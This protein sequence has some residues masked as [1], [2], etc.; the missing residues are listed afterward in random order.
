M[1]LKEKTHFS[2]FFLLISKLR[3]KLIQKKFNHLIKGLHLRKIKRPVVFYLTDLFPKQPPARDEFTHGGQ[4]KLVYLAEAFPHAY[5]FANILYTV[6]SI[7]H[8]LTHKIVSTA[9]KKKMKII[10]NQNGVAYSAWHGPGWEKPNLIHQSIL[11]QADY[12]IYQS[13][14]CQVSAE[15]FLS[16]PDVPCEIIYNPVDVD[17]FTPIHLSKKPKELTLLLG[18]NQYERYRL[19]LAIQTLKTLHLDVPEARLIVTGRLWAPEADAQ[20][21]VHNL[22]QNLNLTEKVIF[23]GPYTQAQAPGIYVQAQILLHTKY[24]DPSPNLISEAMACGLPVAYLKCGGVPELVLDAGIGVDVHESWEEINLPDP[25]KLSAAVLKIMSQYEDFSLRARERAVNYFSLET[26]IEHH[27][28]IF[29]SV[30]G[31]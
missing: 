28:R 26:F 13:R 15:H 30:L 3:L 20:I 25:E 4:V 21:W 22:L 24:N 2:S 11:E 17:H 9:R 8:P 31:F 12:I 14:F 23:T 29:E 16:P 27:Q 18:G 1:K 10:V 5:P 7:G 19:E 6:S